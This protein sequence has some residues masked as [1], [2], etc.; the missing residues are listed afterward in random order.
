VKLL[1]AGGRLVKHPRVRELYPEYLF[2]LHS[3][4][5]SSVPLMETARDRARSIG[6][7]D[8]VAELL[9]EY[10]DKHID[11]ERDHDEWLL[12]D[13]ESIGVDRASI[14]AR[15]PSPT[16][17]RAVG[18]QYY[19]VLHYHPVALLGWIGLLEG[20]PPTPETI[21]ELMAGTG[22]G[23]TA[24][25][26]LSAHAELDVEHR[27]EL[28]DL[29]DRLP[30]TTDQST[31]IGLSAMSSVDLLAQALDEVTALGVNR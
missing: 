13:L 19:W 3:V 9:A 6:R 5:R 2:T 18:A 7:G 14:L 25:R 1:S 8:R 22:Y 28:F 16:V 11:E 17:A 27:D 15:V 31:V 20:Y 29:V 23:P 4:I 10:L 30:L 12:D 24:F 26:T 21:D